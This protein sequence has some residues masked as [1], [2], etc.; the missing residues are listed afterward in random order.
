MTS[1]QNF[2]QKKAGDISHQPRKEY[3]L[4]FFV[5]LCFLK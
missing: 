5:R 2:E 3:V 4:L 1:V